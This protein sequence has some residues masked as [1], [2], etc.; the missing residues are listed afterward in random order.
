MD[1]QIAQAE[2]LNFVACIAAALAGLL[3]AYRLDETCNLSTRFIFRAFVCWMLA[4][5]VWVALWA[6]E[7]LGPFT[8]SK[9]VTLVL[10]DLNTALMMLFYLGLTRGT[11]LRPTGYILSGAIILVTFLIASMGLQNFPEIGPKL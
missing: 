1:P 9:L 10:S 4:W 2:Q 6:L 11:S 8:G 7:W 5:W 3:V